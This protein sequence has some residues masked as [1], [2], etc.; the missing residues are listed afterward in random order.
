MLP[1]WLIDQN[2]HALGGMLT[3]ELSTGDNSPLGRDYLQANQPYAHTAEG[4]DLLIG[5]RIAGKL[6]TLGRDLELNHQPAAAPQSRSEMFWMVPITVWLGFQTLLLLAIS[7]V[8]R[9]SRQV[10][11]RAALKELGPLRTRLG[12]L[13]MGADLTQLNMV[14][15][16]GGESS[17]TGGR[18]EQSQHRR[19]ESSL[20]A[21]WRELDELQRLP[22]SEQRGAAWERQVAHIQELV[23]TLSSQKL[24]LTER[25]EELLRMQP[26]MAAAS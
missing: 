13:A 15:V 5:E 14:A 19:Y 8:G 24:S 12:E 20:A 26:G 10:S 6:L 25:A 11:S 23:K 16:L 22:R 18:A 3:G 2:S 21:A 4:A 1:V 17:P 7:A 9:L